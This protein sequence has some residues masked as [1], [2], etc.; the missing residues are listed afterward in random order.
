MVRQRFH[1]LKQV[2]ARC[3]K[4]EKSLPLGRDLPDNAISQCAARR[5][6]T[7]EIAARVNYNVANWVR[8][9]VAA[10]EVV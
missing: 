10:G 2:S 3:F 1:C 7:V 5:G 4:A 8:P 6:G 9:V